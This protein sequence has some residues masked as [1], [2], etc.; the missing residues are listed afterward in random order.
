MKE[1]FCGGASIGVIH[2]DVLSCGCNLVMIVAGPS[3]EV[4]ISKRFRVF[5][6]VVEGGEEL[7]R[8]GPGGSIAGDVVLQM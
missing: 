5:E 3:L 2:L 6:D 7:T 1:N 4:L 8:V